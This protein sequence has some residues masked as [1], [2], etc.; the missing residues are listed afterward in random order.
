MPIDEIVFAVSCS[1]TVTD[2]FELQLTKMGDK[3][4]NWMTMFQNWS[5]KDE[6]E[7]SIRTFQSV[8]DEIESTFSK[9]EWRDDENGRE[10]LYWKW[11]WLYNKIEI[12]SK[13]HKTWTYVPTITH[14]VAF[15]PGTTT[16]LLVRLTD[17]G[18]EHVHGH[19]RSVTCV[20]RTISRCSWS[21]TVWKIYAIFLLPKYTILTSSL[22]KFSFS[23][24]HIY[25]VAYRVC[26]TFIW[27]RRFCTCMRE[28]IILI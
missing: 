13:C 2:E 18:V 14:V 16:E 1:A 23:M 15:V 7:T 25:C 21:T 27:Y 8:R 28:S 4:R 22:Y 12:S 10:N 26:F 9:I 3:A 6:I 24:L 17:P 11:P 20:V 5:T 19:A